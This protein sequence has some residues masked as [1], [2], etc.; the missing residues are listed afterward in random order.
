[1]TDKTLTPPYGFDD[2]LEIM[3]RLRTPET[4]CAWDLE[5]SFSTIAP[6][7][8]EEAYE[9]ADAIERND[10]ADLSDELGD[11]LLQVVFHAQIA[12]DERQFTI[13]DVTQAISEKMIRRHPH[14]FG[15]EGQKSSEQQVASWEAIKASERATKTEN[16]SS[17]LAGVA[18]ALPALMRAE[19]LQK[20]AARTGFDWTDP[21]DILDKLDEEKAEIVEAMASE[22]PE[23]IEEEIGDLL[24]V[25]ANLARRLKVDPEIALRKANLKFERRFRTMELLASDQDVEFSSLPLDGQEALWNRVKRQEKT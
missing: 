13:A 25:V 11:L 17:A 12:A 16:D 1:M 4:G 7:T 15:E 3:K 9:V 23:H 20:R 22:D 6:Y 5:Q 18:N 21:K 19:K 10:M 8:I 2:L 24:F 14:V